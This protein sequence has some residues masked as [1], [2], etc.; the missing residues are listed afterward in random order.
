MGGA[1]ETA[2]DIKG[3][4][5]LAQ[6]GEAF[7][8]MT[9][10]LREREGL[11]LTLALSETLELEEVLERL[12]DSLG[13]AVRFDHAAVFIKTRDG[14][15][16]TI[17]RGPRHKDEARR[18]ILSS[19]HVNRAIATMQPSLNE[20]R[21][22]LALPLIQR[23]VVIGVV[24]L[25]S[26]HP[27]DL[28]TTRL[29]FSLTQPAAMAVENARLF[30]EVQRL[31]TLD[32]LT[33]TYNRR[34]FMELAQMQFDSAR[35]FSQPLSALMLDVDHFK[36]VND[37][38]G[39]AVGDQVLRGLAD[40]CRTALRSIDVLGRYGG[41]EFAILLPHT[42]RH[43]GAA[44]LAERI[45][46]RVDEEPLNTDAGPIHVTVSVGVA[47]TDDATEDLGALFKRADLALYEA[48]QSGRNRVVEDAQIA[49]KPVA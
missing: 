24:C 47:S 41:E 27:Y 5:E 20:G 4:D 30:D 19:A 14:M 12:L 36:S 45:R 25:E 31:A 1:L 49:E 18:I 9:R 44:V 11:K 34:H 33:G 35:R 46:Q 23:G 21:Q 3:K 10:G 16:V 15:D 8:T 32:G 6:L 48:K 22:M 2:V 37:R 29:A 38:Y 42:E 13:R 7:N 17:S 40:R 39:H 26:H 28:A 43:S